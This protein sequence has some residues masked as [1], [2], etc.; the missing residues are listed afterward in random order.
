VCADGGA[1]SVGSGFGQS[2]PHRCFRRVDEQTA[3]A[4]S[5]DC[6]WRTGREFCFPDSA[7]GRVLRAG[8]NS[9][10]GGFAATDAGRRVFIKQYATEPAGGGRPGS[11]VE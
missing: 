10:L 8:G 11:R 4:A 9:S 5:A 2:S 3:M 6:V 7:V 1:G